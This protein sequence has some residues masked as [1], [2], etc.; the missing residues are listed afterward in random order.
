MTAGAL[1]PCRILVGVGLLIFQFDSAARAGEPVKIPFVQYHANQ[2]F[3]ATGRE[4]GWTTRFQDGAPEEGGRIAE[5]GALHGE[6]FKPDGPGPFPFVILMHGC[7]GM[8][9]TAR[10]W[11]G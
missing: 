9:S 6:L 3:V 1:N 11:I 10:N 8:D 2:K 4:H 5:H 7:G